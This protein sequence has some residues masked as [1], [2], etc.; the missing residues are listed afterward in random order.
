MLLLVGSHSRT[1]LILTE[2]LARNAIV[3]LPEEPA[4]HE[5]PAGTERQ[6]Q[7]AAEVWIDGPRP[8]QAGLLAKLSLL[9]LRPRLEYEVIA[10]S[11]K[12]LRLSSH[13]LF[14]FIVYGVSLHLSAE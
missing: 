1:T 13:I 4:R 11:S 9:K 2:C 5:T 3:A 12:P 10:E 6:G 7:I 14:H 8:V